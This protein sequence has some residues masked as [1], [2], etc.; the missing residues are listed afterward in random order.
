MM[1]S[2]FLDEATLSRSGRPP[3][4]R[5][6]L[7]QTGGHRRDAVACLHQDDVAAPAPR[8]RSRSPDRHAHTAMFFI[9]FSSAARLAS[10][11]IPDSNQNC[12][13]TVRDHSTRVV[14]QSW[15]KIWLMSRR[16]SRMSCMKSLYWRKKACSRVLSS[17]SQLV[18]AIFLQRCCTSRAQAFAGSTFSSWRPPRASGCTIS[19]TYGFVCHGWLPSFLIFLWDIAIG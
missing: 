1:V 15:T 10:P 3:R 14:P 18:L 19:L 8:L 4:S 16:A 13:N 2:V 11:W 9:I 5:H 7:R 17:S 6:W 12:M